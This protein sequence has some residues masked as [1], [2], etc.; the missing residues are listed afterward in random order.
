MHLFRTYTFRPFWLFVYLF[1]V[2]VVLNNVVLC[3]EHNGNVAIEI[4]ACPCSE[5]QSL[6]GHLLDPTEVHITDSCRD[7]VIET[8][9]QFYPQDRQSLH[10]WATEFVHPLDQ[11]KHFVSPTWVSDVISSYTPPPL[12]P[13]IRTAVLLI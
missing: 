6:G 13:S 8:D 1:V 3:L 11:A 5:H 10:Y 4:G 9:S 7:V 12:H 2:Q